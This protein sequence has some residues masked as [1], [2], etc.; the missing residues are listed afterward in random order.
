MRRI[1]TCLLEL[2]DPASG[3]P[4]VARALTKR[5]VGE[6]YGGW[7]EHAPELWQ[8]APGVSVRWRLLDDEHGSDEAFELVWTRLHQADPTLWRR[9]TVQITTTAQD[10]H[11]LVLEQ[12]QSADPKVRPAPG[13][14]TRAPGL[15]GE[16]VRGVAC[17]DGGWR[18]LASP[19]RVGA[20][21][22]ADVDAFVRG[23]RRLP[24][25]LAAPDDRGVVGADSARFAAE[26][27]GLAHVVELTDVAARDAL[28]VELGRGRGA[29]SGGVR[30]LWP[31]WRSS[32]GPLHHPS[33]RAEEVVG[34]DGPR[35]RV[36]EVLRAL[37]LG[38][39]TLRVEGDPLVA[40]LARGQEAS[41]LHERRSELA[42]LRAAVADDRAAAEELIAEYQSELSRA[43]EQVVLLEQELER[44]REQRER[45]EQA[46]LTLAT[47]DRDRPAIDAAQR[48]SNGTLGEVIRR[49]KASRHHLVILPEAE[50]SASQ[51][52]FDRA[53]LVE[54]DLERLDAIA[55]AWAAGSLRA[56]FATTCRE[57]GL[58]WVRDVSA[59]AKQKFPEDYTRVYRGRTIM[60]GPHL[61]RD[62]R[63]LL[64]VYC[65]L[66]EAE[67][68]VV[69]G[70]VG[71]HL[72]DR[73]T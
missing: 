4:R 6:A 59:T 41:D 67:H 3:A 33:W 9:T 43:D 2:A 22:A 61:R 72:R 21:R 28:D 66:D 12:L 73:T 65:Y 31:S 13:G 45:F 15:V 25:V 11:M 69:V 50:R 14:Q 10:G 29:P 49:A 30:L 26:L 52:H 68:R 27:V 48:D 23:D 18:L 40:R 57:R 16:L 63:Q 8:P 5:W 7:P 42:T 71:R 1:Y 54:A 19:Q 47:G 58:D 46:Y 37:V 60:L 39:A 35:A 55:A 62:G 56:D 70:H 51:W 34:P 64:R 20:G 17:V 53:D 24:V 44:E 36:A 38:A 32:D